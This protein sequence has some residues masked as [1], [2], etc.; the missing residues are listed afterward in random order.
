VQYEEKYLPPVWSK[1]TEEQIKAGHGGMDSIEF[2]VFVDCLKEGRE[3]PIDVY[4]AAAWMSITALSAASIAA[5]GQVQAIPD[6]TSGQWV[7]R[8]PMDVVEMD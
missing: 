4:D 3:M 7:K 1:M 6:F 2:R 8:P 5:G